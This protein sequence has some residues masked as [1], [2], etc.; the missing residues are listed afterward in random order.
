VFVEKTLLDPTLQMFI[1]KLDVELIKCIRSAGC[2]PKAKEVEET[3]DGAEVCKVSVLVQ[4]GRKKG[5][6]GFGEAVSIIRC[7][8]D[9]T[10]LL[11]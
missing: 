5:V 9:G 1:G 6:K 8:E 7:N 10:Q 2:I 4:P 3:D 11:V